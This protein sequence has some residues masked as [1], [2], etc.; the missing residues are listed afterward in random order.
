MKVMQAAQAAVLALLGYRDSELEHEV[1][2][3]AYLDGVPAE[4]ALWGVILVVEPEDALDVQLNEALGG[5]DLDEIL[6]VEAAYGLG[7]RPPATMIE[8]VSLADRPVETL[9]RAL[10]K[11][12]GALV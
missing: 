12:R 2:V 6:I 10:G 9:Q 8:A 4:E 1:A 11:L 5:L 3:K 7:G